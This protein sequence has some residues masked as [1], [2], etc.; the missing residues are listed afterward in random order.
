MN[1][2]RLYAVNRLIDGVF[3]I[4]VYNAAKTLLVVNK[5]SRL[6]KAA[7]LIYLC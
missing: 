3:I 5:K 6:I 2:A 1:K 4:R 7:F